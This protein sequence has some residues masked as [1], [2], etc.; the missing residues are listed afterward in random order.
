MKDLPNWKLDQTLRAMHLLSVFKIDYSKLHG[1]F[2]LMYS[3]KLSWSALPWG[4]YSWRH[5]V[6]CKTIL[7]SNYKTVRIY[8]QLLTQIWNKW[9]DSSFFQTVTVTGYIED[10]VLA[11]VSDVYYKSSYCSRFLN[12]HW[13]KYYESK[14]EICLLLFLHCLILSLVHLMKKTVNNAVT[15]ITSL[16]SSPL[17]LEK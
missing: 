14:M 1:H 12:I 15:A 2:V 4:K 16:V 8:P 11:G 6:S 7:G 5:C 9:V 3:R 13:D 10:L 17:M